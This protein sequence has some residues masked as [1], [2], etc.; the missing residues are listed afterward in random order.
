MKLVFVHDGPL[1]YDS[2]GRYYEFAYHELY[3]RYSYFAD[4]ITFLMRTKPI[5]G[6]RKFTL[7]PSE[8]RVV[9]VPN[10]KSPKLYFKNKKTAQE[11]VKK[12][13]F[14]ADYVV[15]R[16][17]SSIAQLAL[18]YIKEYRKP[19]IIECVGCSWDSYWNHGLLGKIVAPYMYLKTRCAIRNAEYVYYVTNEFLQK[20]YPTNGKTVSCSNVVL[21]S[22][23][24]YTLE[25]RIKK[26]QEFNP[27]KRLI[28]GTA[29]AIDTRYKGHEH[30]IEAIPALLKKGYNIEYRLAGGF[31]GQK[32][33][34]FLYDLARNLGVSDRVTFCG[35]LSSKQMNEYYDSLDIYVQPSKQEGLPRA[36]IEAMS[37]A[38]PTIGTGIAG[39]PELLQKDFL[40]K[41]GSSEEVVGA[42]ERMLK[43]DL[44]KVATVNFEKAKQYERDKLNVKRNLFYDQFI[45]DIAIKGEG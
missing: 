34:T 23:D 1:F 19:Y 9:D 27:N 32:K 18:N 10:F 30:V 38:C 36:V 2:E 12:E 26:I 41:K 6:E 7:V 39:I 11:I 24:N 37:R 22:L 35:S 14:A 21:D 4:D 16:S 44:S 33:T 17:Q 13:I 5:E 42:I 43:A 40:F 45:Q 28:L 3:Q 8:I 20:R 31:T 15:L 29:A 25:K